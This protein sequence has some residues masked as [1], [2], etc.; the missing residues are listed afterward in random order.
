M[1]TQQSSEGTFTSLK[2]GLILGPGRGARSIQ[3]RSGC[4]RKSHNA[5]IH[6]LIWGVRRPAE[7]GTTSLFE[8]VEL[9]AS[10]II[11]RTELVAALGEA[12]LNAFSVYLQPPGATMLDDRNRRSLGA[13]PDRGLFKDHQFRVLGIRILLRRPRTTVCGLSQNACP[14]A[15]STGQRSVDMRLWFARP[16]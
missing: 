16:I 13:L 2:L 11:R 14:G 6:S 12:R 4:T 7:Q 1:L 5:S 10:R 9:L 8:N 15:T 3:K